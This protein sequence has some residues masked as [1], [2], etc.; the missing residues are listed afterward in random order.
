MRECPFL[1]VAFGWAVGGG[2]FCYPEDV[3]YEVGASDS[4]YFV[5]E[6]HYDNP[7][8]KEGVLDSSGMKI[9]TLSKLREK[10]VG[11]VGV[12]EPGLTIKGLSHSANDVIGGI[13]IEPHKSPSSMN[14]CPSVCTENGPS[15][16]HHRD[17]P[18]PARASAGPQD[19]NHSKGWENGRIARS[20]LKYQL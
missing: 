1:Q 19:H 17:C 10:S 18:L 5:L 14:N 4:K 16:N 3:G 2:A 15:T 9:T 8:N 12:G 11:T 7:H 13:S 20:C 6:I